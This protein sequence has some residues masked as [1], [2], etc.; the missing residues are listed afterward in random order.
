M[1]TE[2]PTLKIRLVK[3]HT[4]TGS[5]VRRLGN[6]IYRVNINLR[7]REILLIPNGAAK[8]AVYNCITSQSNKFTEARLQRWSGK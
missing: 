7:H 5:S 2:K 1:P 8:K 3:T 6:T 4:F